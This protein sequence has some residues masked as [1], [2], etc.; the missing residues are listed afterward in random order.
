MSVTNE[1][2][3]AIFRFGHSMVHQNISMLGYAQE[4]IMEDEILDDHFFEPYLY[5]A[6]QGRGLE[7]IMMWT[8]NTRCPLFDT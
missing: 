2:A 3:A 8:A 4:F 1:F 7:Y 6:N 5:H